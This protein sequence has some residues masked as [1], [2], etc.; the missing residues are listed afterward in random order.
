M[1]IGRNVFFQL[2]KHGV[3]CIVFGVKGVG[4]V[5]VLLVSLGLQA[6]HFPV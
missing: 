4:K 6:D 5:D 3:A 1:N 2:G